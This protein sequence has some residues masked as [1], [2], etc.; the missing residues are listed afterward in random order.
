MLPVGSPA[1]DEAETPHIGRRVLAGLVVLAALGAGG[2]Y[3]WT[4]FAP[5]KDRPGRN[6]SSPGGGDNVGRT[7]AE[8][9]M[10]APTEIWNPYPDMGPT[11]IRLRDMTGRCGISTI[12]HS[13]A[14]GV[15]EFLIEAVGVG[16]ACLDYDRDGWMDVYIPDGDMFQNY[17][18]VEVAVPGR[19]RLRA[20]LQRKAVVDKSFHDQLWR[21]NGDGTFTDV[22]PQAGVADERWSFGSTALDY[23]GDGWTDLYV[24]N[25]GQNRL[26]RNNGNGTFTD[27]AHETGCARDIWTWSTCSAAADLDGDDRLDLYVSA[28]ADPAHEVDRMRRDRNLPLG[29]PVETIPGRACRWK[30]VNAYCGPLG[31]DAQEDAFLR[32]NTDGN[33]EDR[34]ETQGFRTKSGAKYGFQ[35]LGCDLNDD[36]WT[37]VYVANDSVES[38]LW[39]AEPQAQGGVRFR[40]NA[41]NL[42][43]K[44]STTLAPQAG[45][46]AA[47][48]DFNQDGWFDVFK[49][50]FTQDYNNMYMGQRTGAGK[51][52]FRDL[53]LQTMG[54]AVFYDLSWGCGWHDLD[55][56][57]DLELYVANGH[58]YKEVDDQPEMGATYAQYNALFE[59]VEAR[60]LGYREIGRKAV[61][62]LGA[63]GAKLFAGDGMD[64]K[65][66]SRGVAFVDLNNDGRTDILVTNMNAP[67]NVIVNDTPR[68]PDRNWA[69]LVL[70]QPGPNGEALGASLEVVA[71]DVRQRYPVS[72]GSSFLGSDDP[73]LNVGLGAATTF[74][75]KVVWPGAKRETTTYTGLAAGRLWKLHREGGRAEELP[76][77][78]F[79]FNLPPEP[80]GTQQ[81]GN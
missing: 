30:R 18:L 3:A 31:L 36:G 38:F 24:S 16:A 5:G 4:R 73:R 40:E 42:G 1:M 33:F 39:I 78:T 70:E 7:M 20:T 59:C 49:T 67:V 41:D 23:D 15:K 53:G 56:D 51:T 47:V 10:P 46:G 68:A 17:D 74:D 65:A 29:T 28:Y 26:Y 6:P 80:P 13:G 12:N 55:G 25:F 60:R 66:C 64:I 81:P 54:Q 27:V 77:E 58:V 62:R 43:V 69:K 63:H 71:G 8:G 14:A 35:A 11:R 57:G 9:S 2:W 22:A 19:D 61:D 79:A 34:S 50:N 52:F 75:V 44:F 76:L 45:M 37:D 32:Q 48:H 21:N 72:R